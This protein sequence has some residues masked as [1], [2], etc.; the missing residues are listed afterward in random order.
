MHVQW[1]AQSVSLISIRWIVI[2]RV[3][4]T[5]QRLNNPGQGKS[6]PITLFALLTL[7][8]KKGCN[9]QIQFFSHLLLISPSC[10]HNCVRQ[11]QTTYR[12]ADWQVN[13]EKIRLK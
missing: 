8:K 10:Y 13:E 9:G 5:I 12:F 11:M 2:Y 7:S 4:S 6:N 3:D 1:I